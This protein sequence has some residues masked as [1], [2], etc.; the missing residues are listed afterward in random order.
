MVVPLFRCR[1][2]YR[3]SS[4]RSLGVAGTDGGVDVVHAIP[5]QHVE[6]AVGDVLIRPDQGARR[7]RE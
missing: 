4:R 3:F 2:V 5:E 7:R 6:G 1:V